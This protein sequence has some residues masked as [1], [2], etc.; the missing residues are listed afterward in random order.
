MA[1]EAK[2]LNDVWARPTAQLLEDERKAAECD[3]ATARAE[4]AE[5]KLAEARKV[6]VEA[7][8]K[9]ENDRT[10]YTRE[11]QMWL[12]DAR[13]ALTEQDQDHG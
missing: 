7:M 11:W 6:L 2:R 4:T 3:T 8:T 5:R 10:L 12:A 13:A 9:V 1:A